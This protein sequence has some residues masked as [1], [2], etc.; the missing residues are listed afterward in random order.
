MVSMYMHMLDY[1]PYYYYD[2]VESHFYNGNLFPSMVLT[3]SKVFLLESEEARGILLGQEA[4]VAMMKR[5]FEEHKSQCVPCT[6]A[7]MDGFEGY[8]QLM[9]LVE[10]TNICSIQADPCI[11]PLL[12]A[13]RRM[14]ILIGW[15]LG[16]TMRLSCRVR[17]TFTGRLRM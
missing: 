8:G 16:W 13:P 15:R 2:S 6:T 1:H 17:R 12:S 3:S 9:D 5:Q 4:A 11:L 10:S 7:V 14:C